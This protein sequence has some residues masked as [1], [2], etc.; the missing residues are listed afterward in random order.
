MYQ[1]I[2]FLPLLGFLIAGLF[3][4]QLGARPAELVTTGLLFVLPTSY[5]VVGGRIARAGAA[6]SSTM[7]AP[8][9]KETRTE[10]RLRFRIADSTA[11][12][13]LRKL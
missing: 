6:A 13:V 5:K 12:P 7:R 8:I 2:V 10:P 9:M 3:G 4:R 11:A 1:A